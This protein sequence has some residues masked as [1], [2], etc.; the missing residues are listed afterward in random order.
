[1]FC[2]EMD[3]ESSR[4]QNPFDSGHINYS[5]A[6]GDLNGDGKL[7]FALAQGNGNQTARL[8]NMSAYTRR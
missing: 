7:D 2:L 6:L 1:M 4:R 5:D 3:Q 8:L